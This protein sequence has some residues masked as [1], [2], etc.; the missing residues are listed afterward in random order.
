FGDRGDQQAGLRALP[1]LPGQQAEQHPVLVGGRG[2][3]QLVHQVAAPALR[4][5]P[6]LRADRG[7]RGVHLGHRQGRL[8][9]RR[10][11]LAYRG[12]TDPDLP[13][14][15]L[16]GQVGGARLQFV[17][18]EDAQRPGEQVDLP[19]PRRGGGDGGGGGGEVDEPHGLI[20]AATA[21]SFHA[22]TGSATR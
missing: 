10:R 7:E 5:R 17:G 21:D 18:R 2:G 12:P 8:G 15:Q 11:R 14:A 20:L 19:P 22:S 4:S 6:G 9:G 16:A 13:L 1:Q 3:E